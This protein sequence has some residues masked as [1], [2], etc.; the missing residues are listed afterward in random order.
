MKE[1]C[2]RG[3]VEDEY[4]G[5]YCRE[6]KRGI[7]IMMRDNNVD[8]IVSVIDEARRLAEKYMN[9]AASLYHPDMVPDTYKLPW[10][11]TP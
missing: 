10:E 7:E 6:C 2:C 8:A 9:I 3:Y 1:R 11:D 4:G 5:K